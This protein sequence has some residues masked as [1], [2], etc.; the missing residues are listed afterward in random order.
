MMCVS[1]RTCL[2]CYLTVIVPGV[3]G[4]PPLVY[5]LLYGQQ[6]PLQELPH[7]IHITA[8][9]PVMVNGDCVLLTHTHTQTNGALN[10]IVIV[11]SFFFLK[12]K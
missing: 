8:V 5:L 11:Y 2:H 12:H 4:V 7:H 3:H 6:L 10:K 1:Y 9:Q